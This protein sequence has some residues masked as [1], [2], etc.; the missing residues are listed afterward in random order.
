MRTCSLMVE[1]MEQ[2][3]PSSLLVWP[4]RDRSRRSQ[5]EQSRRSQQKQQKQQSQHPISTH[6]LFVPL[7]KGKHLGAIKGQKEKLHSSRMGLFFICSYYLNFLIS[8]LQYLLAANDIDALLHLAQTLTS[9][10][11][12]GSLILHY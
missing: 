4:S 9:K 11:V 1:L 12:Y 10:I 5:C 2:R 8:S 3:A 6:I 7:Q